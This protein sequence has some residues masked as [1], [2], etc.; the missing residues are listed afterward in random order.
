[1]AI[2][3]DEIDASLFVKGRGN[4]NLKGQHVFLSPDWHNPIIVHCLNWQ[5]P[6]IY[7][8]ENRTQILRTHENCLLEIAQ[9]G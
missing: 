1:M 4:D 7:L 9:L 6:Q 2:G 3:K 5:S 8:E